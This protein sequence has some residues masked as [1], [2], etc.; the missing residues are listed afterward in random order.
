M[1]FRK[2]VVGVGSFFFASLGL[3]QACADTPVAVVDE[4]SGTSADATPDTRVPQPR[5]DAAVPDSTTP[6]PPPVDASRDSAIPDAARDSATGDGGTGDRPGDPFDPLAPKAGDPCPVGTNVNDTIDRRCGLCGMQR[7]L[8]EAGRIVGTYGACM[9]ESSSSSACL[10][11]LRRTVACGTCGTKAER[12]NNACAIESGLCQNEVAGGC[13]AGSIR[14]LATC[15]DPDQV[16]RQSCSATCVLGA[17]EACGPRGAD[18]TVDVSQTVGGVVAQT[19]TPDAAN[20][21]LGLS[22]PYCPTALHPTIRTV[23]SYVLLRNTGAQAANVTVTNKSATEVALFAAYAGTTLPADRTTCQEHIGYNKFTVTIASGASQLVYVGGNTATA[24]GPYPLDIRTNFL[25]PEPA[26]TP[27][28]T[29]NISQT[30]GGVATQALVFDENRF[31]PFIAGLNAPADYTGAHPCPVVKTGYE[32]PYRYV[33]LNNTGATPRTVNLITTSDGDD[34]FM[35]TYAAVPTLATR[36]ACNGNYND[37]CTAA[38]GNACL[39]AVTVP[40]TGSIVVY[41]G[42]FTDDGDLDTNTLQVTT[43][44]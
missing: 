29:L 30:M 12:C 14:Y 17:P 3:M 26:P 28:H 8:C 32:F 39:N 44:N 18:T 36:R 20:K 9:N 7:A 43:T 21:I 15:A 11:G 27:D 34:T 24:T 19:I 37:D 41:I 4:D 23:F 38:D 2:G 40:A 10:P 6:V 31:L 25:G 42:Q 5:F 33:R 13:V 22:S 35:A 16:R 1:S